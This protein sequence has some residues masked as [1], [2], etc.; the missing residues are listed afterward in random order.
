MM[1][2]TQ[3]VV[4]KPSPDYLACLLLAMNMTALYAVLENSRS[5][6]KGRQ[7]QL[8]TLSRVNFC[9]WT[10]T[11]GILHHVVCSLLSSP[12]LMPRQECCG[13]SAHQAR[14]HPS[15]YYDGS[16]PTYAARSKCCQISVLMEM[17]PW[18][19]PQHLQLISAMRNK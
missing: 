12:S 7:H 5:F 1:F 14:S 10:S 16:S 8:T 13:S 9:I 6:A 17:A 2:S 3:C 15:I 11:S 4:S 18:L 19:G